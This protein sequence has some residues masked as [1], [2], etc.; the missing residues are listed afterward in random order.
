M[1]RAKRKPIDAESLS[2][3]EG[4][5]ESTVRRLEAKAAGKAPSRADKVQV[6]AFVPEETR[7]RLK[8]LA[9]ANGR[10]LN[11]LLEEGFDLLFAKYER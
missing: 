5:P 6:S 1:S 4:A 10:S 7:R 9:T 3:I 2:V 8:M 11:D